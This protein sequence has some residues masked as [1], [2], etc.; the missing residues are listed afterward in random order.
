MHPLSYRSWFARVTPAI[1][2]GHSPRTQLLFWLL[3]W[4]RAYAIVITLLSW[5]LISADRTPDILNKAS[6][7]VK[8]LS[9]KC[10]GRQPK[11]ARIL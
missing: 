2:Q 8:G 9:G 10:L 5:S 3:F 11:T 4:M 7:S 1:S 6:F